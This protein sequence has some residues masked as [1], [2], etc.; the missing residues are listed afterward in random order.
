M[1]RA[2]KFSSQGDEYQLQIGLH[3]VIQLLEDKSIDFIQV[4]STGVPNLGKPVT[5]DDVVIFFKDS[6]AKFAQAKKNSPQHTNWSIKTIGDELRKAVLQ[7][8]AYENCSILF[9]SQSPWGEVKSLV[10]SCK[11]YPDFTA[12]QNA[13]DVS[14]KTKDLLPSLSEIISQPESEA[15]RL[16]CSISFG[17]PFSIEEWERQN[18]NALSRIIPRAAL[19]IDVIRGLLSKHQIN[20]PGTPF[21]LTRDA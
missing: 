6:C 9:Y 1:S 12:F 16:A 4:E 21:K 17:E 14:A 18:L 15:F 5:V 10:E 3:W 8:N 11:I 19:G 20:L 2:G 13:L 7:L